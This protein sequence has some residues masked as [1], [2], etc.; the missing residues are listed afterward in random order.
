[1]TRALFGMIV[2]PRLSTGFV[3]IRT[4]LQLLGHIVIFLSKLFQN[5]RTLSRSYSGEQPA[6]FQGVFTVVG[7]GVHQ[8]TRLEKLTDTG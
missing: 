8:V 5:L 6:R 1:M 4:T 7:R 3:V 2:T